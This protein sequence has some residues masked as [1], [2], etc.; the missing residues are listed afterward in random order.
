MATKPLPPKS[1][2]ML[3]CGAGSRA[4]SEPISAR[5]DSGG[6]GAG[7]DRRNNFRDPAQ[8]LGALYAFEAQ[9][10]ATAASKLEGPA[11]ALPARAGGGSLLRSPQ[12]RPGRARA[13][14]G[15]DGRR[16]RRLSSN[17]RL[18]LARRWRRRCELRWTVCTKTA[19]RRPRSVVAA[20]VLKRFGPASGMRGR[21]GSGALAV[22]AALGR[23]SPAPAARTQP[24]T[25]SMGSPRSS[26][27]FPTAPSPRRRWPR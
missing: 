10:P 19:A 2:S 20:T 4:R 12:G 14:A 6:G 16:C 9:Q 21:F 24:E 22:K 7:G 26:R 27:G 1:A 8:S 11:D 25:R 13:A 15:A 5:R 3:S 17:G 23:T 18:L